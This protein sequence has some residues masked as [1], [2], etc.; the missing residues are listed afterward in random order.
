MRR[1]AKHGAAVFE[2]QMKKCGIEILRLH[3]PSGWF[4]GS[5]TGLRR[6]D[7]ELGAFAW[8]GQTD[9]A[10]THA[11]LLH[12]NPGSREWLGKVR[13][14]WAGAI[15]RR[16]TPSTRR[17]TPCCAKIAR[18]FYKI[19]QVEFSKDMVSLPVFQRAEGNAATKALKN[20]KPST[21]EYYTWNSYEWELDGGRDSLV[22]GLDAR[23]GK[24]VLAR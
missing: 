10:W 8:V 13:T 1:S 22:L 16:V 5:T 12:P 3:T 23:T 9:P 20:F 14:T 4:F 7:F 2:A 11:L 18:S 19:V 6:R 17:T 15:R 24:H 21:T